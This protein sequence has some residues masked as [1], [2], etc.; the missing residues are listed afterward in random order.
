[1]GEFAAALA[2]EINQPLTAIAN[3]ARVATTARDATVAMEASKKMLV[4]VERAAEVVR[5]LR[6]FIQLGSHEATRISVLPLLEDALRYCHAESVSIGLRVVPDLPEVH[7]DGLQIQQ[8]IVNLVRNAAEAIAREGRS[9][10]KVSIH[11]ALNGTDAVLIQVRDNGPGFDPDLVDHASH[12]FTSSKPDGLGL[13]LSLARSI[14]E[15]H[16]GSLA[17]S[18]TSNGAIVSFTLPIR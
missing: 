4:Q 8:V 10:G 6:N 11:A 15:A 5:R 18:S 13:G 14:I 12:P 1:M 17:I 16:G 3:Y 2:H 9:D 7:A